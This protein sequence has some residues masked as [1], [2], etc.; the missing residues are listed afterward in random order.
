MQTENNPIRERNISELSTESTMK[1][2]FRV[3]VSS[4]GK[5]FHRIESYL[6]FKKK[7]TR[8]EL[9]MKFDADY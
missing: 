8:E 4:C 2:A 3:N 1:D 5:L 7:R 9:I 6:N